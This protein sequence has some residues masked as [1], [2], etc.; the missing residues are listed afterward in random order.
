[1]L[2]DRLYICVGMGGG[3]GG[4]GGGGWRQGQGV[5]SAEGG[6]SEIADARI[7]SLYVSVCVHV[8]EEGG[9]GGGGGGSTSGV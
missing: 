2:I 5:I 7:S 9:G 4:G 1:M 8:W 6:N 3:G